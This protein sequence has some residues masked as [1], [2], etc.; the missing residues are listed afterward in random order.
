MT[1]AQCRAA[2]A[3]VEMTQPDLAKASG[4]G[5]STVVDF[6]KGRRAVSAGALAA[7]RA[8][9]E[10]AGVVFVEENGEGAGVR[11]RKTWEPG[12]YARAAQHGPATVENVGTDPDGVIRAD[13]SVRTKK[14]I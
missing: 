9:L 14:S 7:F 5:L 2:R 4:F 3:L 12:D 8:A 1:P 6:E 11:L 13:R 10:A